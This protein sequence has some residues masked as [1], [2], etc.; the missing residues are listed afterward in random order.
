[1]N[2][3]EIAQTIQEQ[4]K[5]FLGM[6]VIWSWGQSA[7]QAVSGEQL[8]HLGISGLGG[9]K[10]KV[11]GMHHKGHVLVSLNFADTYDVYICSIRKDTMTVKEKLE[12]LY[13][14]EFG[15]WIDEQVEL[16]EDYT[17]AEILQDLHK[18]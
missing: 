8:K 15:T 6:P 11:N 10:F 3:T 5:Q 4:L 14:D 16:V 18:I 13:L 17:T 7:L 1:M 2:P 12:G 9:L